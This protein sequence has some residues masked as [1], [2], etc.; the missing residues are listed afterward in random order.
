MGACTADAGM[1]RASF[2]HRVVGLLLI[3]LAGL[4]AGLVTRVP[5]GQEGGESSTLLSVPGRHAGLLP[6]GGHLRSTGQGIT[7]KR[8]C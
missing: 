6:L 4:P 2:P 7:E 1:L 8:W 3:L 5:D